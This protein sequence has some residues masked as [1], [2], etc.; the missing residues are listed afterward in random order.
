MQHQHL[1]NSQI[2]QLIVRFAAITWKMFSST[3][4]LLMKLQ[5]IFFYE[6]LMH[7]STFYIFGVASHTGF[8]RKILIFPQNSVLMAPNAWLMTSM[9]M[10]AAAAIEGSEDTIRYDAVAQPAKD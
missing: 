10:A 2:W 3:V 5:T 1:E 8:L 9:L 4:I 6:N 7:E